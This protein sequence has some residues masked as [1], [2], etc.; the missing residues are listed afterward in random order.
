MPPV[1]VKCMEPDSIKKPRALL[2]PPMSP[3]KV[4]H[5]HML[6]SPVPKKKAVS[7]W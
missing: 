4:N 5:W 7:L 1:K 6:F 3:N 2:M